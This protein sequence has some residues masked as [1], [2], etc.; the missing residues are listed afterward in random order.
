MSAPELESRRWDGYRGMVA[1]QLLGSWN[2]PGASL[3]AGY[4]TRMRAAIDAMLCRLP[5][6]YSVRARAVTST[7]T[8]MQLDDALEDLAQPPETP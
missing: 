4:E 6:W 5:F 3:Q 8:A 7:S 1:P 2:W